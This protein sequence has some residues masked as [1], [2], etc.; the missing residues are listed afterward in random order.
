MT[1]PAKEIASVEPVP[2]LTVAKYEH[3][4]ITERGVIFSPETPVDYW[5]ETTKKALDMFEGATGV[6]LRARIAV[7]DC[8]NFGEGNF[9]ERYA[10]AIDSTRKIIRLSMK[11][12]QNDAWI[13]GS[14]PMAN[15]HMML[16]IGYHEAVAKI[17]DL[18][19]QREWLDKTEENEWSIRELR[20]EIK[21]VH[22]SKKKAKAPSAKAMIDFGDEKSVLHALEKI[23]EYIY[24]EKC[25]ALQMEDGRQ[26]EFS[27]RIL[28]VA[29]A[30]G[31]TM[32]NKFFERLCTITGKY[33]EEVETAEPIREWSANRKERWTKGL[34]AAAKAARRGKIG[35]FA[36]ERKPDEH[37][38]PGKSADA[39][40]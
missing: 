27:G 5:L 39:Q 9:K 18:E 31:V 40:E 22:P 4:E 29:E 23:A 13:F 10:Q 35:R 12:L 32:N 8:L 14:V 21:K 17:T 15:R 24:G 30:F 26:K 36:S 2:F 7:A 28:A 1:K 37:A 33:L 11:T 20:A 25:A 34:E 3:H 19:E 6:T 38:A 16:E